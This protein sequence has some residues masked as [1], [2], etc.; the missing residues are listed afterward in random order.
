M[1]LLRSKLTYA[2]IISTLCL[3][4]L[5]GGGAAVAADQLAKNSVGTKQLKGNAVTS[6]KI[7]N[8]AVT[9]AKIK[10]GAITGA[11]VNLGS[12]GTVPSATSAGTA[13][14][15]GNANTVNGQTVQK[16]FALVPDGTAA[17]RAIA[18]FAGFT[19]TSTCSGTNPD[20]DLVS[21]AGIA[22]DMKSQGNG[23]GINPGPVIGGAQGPG[24]Q[25]LELN[26]DG[27]NDND[28]G[29]TNFSAALLNGTVV[30]GVIGFEDSESFVDTDACAIYGHVTIGG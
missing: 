19:L 13:A 15:A 27:T 14:S 12:L 28:R 30:S 10:D 4:L 24:P 8:G 20:I 2:N 29:E 22:A 1:K 21:P 23:G 18:T 16:V 9:S 6:A 7:K 17:P 3:F 26:R 25:T 5:L 11:K